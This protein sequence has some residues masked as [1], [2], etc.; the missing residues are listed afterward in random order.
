MTLFFY[1]RTPSTLPISFFTPSKQAR[2][3]MTDQEKVGCTVCLEPVTSQSVLKCCH[4]PCHAQCVNQW[5][6][7]RHAISCPRYGRPIIVL[8]VKH[9]EMLKEDA[10]FVEQV[11]NLWKDSGFWYGVV[12][13]TFG[14]T[15]GF[16]G[17]HKDSKE[18]TEKTRFHLGHTKKKAIRR[19]KS[20][21]SCL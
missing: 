7:V 10:H 17:E 4:R 19:M 20:I 5:K 9:P 6:K 13:D 11:K 8:E 1:K 12:Y 2:I 16:W 3:F 21:L 14:S 15:A 18:P